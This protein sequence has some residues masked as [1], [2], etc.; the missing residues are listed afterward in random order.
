MIGK[1]NQDDVEAL[2]R[3]IVDPKADWAENLFKKYLFV[4]E[5]CEYNY[6]FLSLD[7]DLAAITN[8]ELDH[9]DVYGTFENY[10]DTFVQFCKKAKDGILCFEET[11]GLS[12]LEEKTEAVFI[13]VEHKKFNFTTL[14]WA[15]NHDNASLALAICKHLCKDEVTE[16]ELTQSLES[17][18]GLR[19]RGEFLGKNK[20]GVH[21]ITDY[22]HHPTELG[23]TLWAI[24]EKRPD[25]KL[26]LLFQPHQ[27]RRVVEFWDEFIAAMTGINDPIIYDIYT[28]DFQEIKTIIDQQ[29]EGI[30]LICTAG[31]LDWEVRKGLDI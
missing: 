25:Q 29:E 30:I 15:H 7:V 27:A 8:I 11:Q 12:L 16:S 18:G 13:N 24:K 4:I 1:Q 6:Q 14:L 10:L 3:S 9:A 28:A 23:S 2:L 22:A 21:I 26:T 19:R 20:Q 17:F 31:N 5:A